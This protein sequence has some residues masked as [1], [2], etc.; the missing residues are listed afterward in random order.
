MPLIK[1]A[2]GLTLIGLTSTIQAREITGIAATVNGRVITNNEINYHLTPYRQRLD[3]Q[4][5]NK[6]EAYKKLL[7]EAQTDILDSMIE[8]ELILSEFNTKL[9]GRI[10]DHAI[11]GEIKRQIRELYNN[12]R[13]E[14]VKALKDAGM[15]PQQHRRETEKKLIVQAMRTQQ[16]K[17]AA[18]PLPSEINA[19]YQK[20]KLKMRDI[21]GDALEGHKIYI[22]K[23]DPNNA[24]IVPE[25]QLE[26][27][28]DIV[29]QLKK[30]ADF[31][32]LARKHS[33]DSY[34]DDGGKMEKT[35]RTDLS[36]A[37][38]AILMETDEGVVLG[39]LEDARGFTI[40]RVDKKYYGPAPS[41]NKVRDQIK[42]RVSSRKNKDRQ[43]RWIK[44]LRANAVIV[45]KI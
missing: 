30:G 43:D 32:T 35:P 3:A 24:L 18:P 11:D 38:A 41:L 1:L 22:Q 37:F 31:A 44:R 2:F 33:S 6:T 45:I 19:E 42:A 9:K 29:D 4:M 34:A 13:S 20:H 21:T 7:S 28:E 36:P 23:F 26:L 5:P 40:V 27:A 25:I 15:S 10:P 17:A 14:Y 39:P 8:R 12:S 16:F